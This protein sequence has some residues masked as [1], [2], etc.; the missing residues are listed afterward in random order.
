MIASIFLVLLAVHLCFYLFLLIKTQSRIIQFEKLTFT[1]Y[2][3]VLGA[4]LEKNNL[5]TDI[6]SDRLET[7]IDLL[8]SNKTETLILSGSTDHHNYNEPLSMKKYVLSKG[9]NPSH[10]IL[11]L[12]G[13]STFDSLRNLLIFE[14]LNDITIVSQRFHLPRSI[15]L[16]GALGINAKGTPAENFK[17]SFIKIFSW[18][19]REI[20]AIPLNILKFILYSLEGVEKISKN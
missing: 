17:F 3:L 8:K 11:D 10:L 5:P 7:A 14:G 9:I 15:W 16:A 12:K 6:L 18:Y 19:L 1:R 2:T 20:F 4:G 13:N